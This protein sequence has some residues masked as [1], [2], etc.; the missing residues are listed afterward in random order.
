MLEP[1]ARAHWP[2]TARETCAILSRVFYIASM[3]KPLEGLSP[4]LFGIIQGD[5]LVLAYARSRTHLACVRRR[6]LSALS[7]VANETRSL[8]HYGVCSSTL[9]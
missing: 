2:Q 4:C 1:K 3:E 7:T 8:K 9:S 6:Q 5:T